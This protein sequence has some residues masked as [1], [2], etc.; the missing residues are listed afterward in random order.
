METLKQFGERFDE[1]DY[2]KPDPSKVYL[3][4]LRE[5]PDNTWVTVVTA[6]QAIRKLEEGNV[7]V[8]DLDHD[9][10]LKD[11]TGYDVLKWIEE[12]TFTDA[13]YEPPTILIHTSNSSAEKLM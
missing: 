12:K 5:P 4:D 6:K 2:V 10:G 11:E 9:L 7:E 1:T 13:K 3:D 8:I